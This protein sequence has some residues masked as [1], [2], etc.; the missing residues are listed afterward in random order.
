MS[1]QGSPSSAPDN[2]I[3]GADA[4]PGP[5]DS[6]A[7]LVRERLLRRMFVMG[8]PTVL[9][10]LAAA[11]AMAGVFFWMTRGLGALIWG[12]VI[13]AL[14]GLR[15]VFM[16]WNARLYP[17]PEF[18]LRQP[19]GAWRFMLPLGAYMSMWTLAPWALMPPGTES[20]MR[21][22]IL[23]LGMFAVLMGSVPVIAT[24]RA[25]VPVVTIP[26]TLGVVTR[27]AWMGG[28]DGWF[29]CVVGLL[30]G[31]SMARYALS[32]HQLIRRSL[33]DQIDKELLSEQLLRQS[34]EL[35]RLN[36]ERSRFFASASHDLRQPV[37]A[38]A[39]FS[40][41]LERDL[42]D[43][44]LAPV[45][46]RVVQATD[47]VSGL[48]NAM[49]DISKID[50]G[51]VVPQ[52]MEIA[53][54][55]L[56]L[57][58]SQLFE[59]RAQQ[60]GLS[61]RFHTGPEWLQTDADLLLRVLNNFVDNALK[62]TRRGGIL[63]SARPRGDRLR[64]AVWDTG[65]G[66][67]PEHLPHVFDEFYQVDN[68]QRDVARGLGIGLAIVKRLVDLLGGEVGVRSRQD[69][70]SVFWVDLPRR[71]PAPA[72]PALAPTATPAPA[73]IDTTELPLVPPRV[74]LLDDEQPV[75]EAVRMWLA[76]YC[77][78]IEITTRLS[79][80]CAQVRATPEDFD[81]FIVD[82]RLADPQDGIQAT[83][84]LRQ[85]AGRRVPTIL[86]TG[87]TDPE[88][89][90]AAYAS[91]LVVMFK[92]VQPEVLLRTLHQIIRSEEREPA[93]SLRRRQPP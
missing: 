14:L 47:A 76:P 87:D 29:T 45:A 31:G 55:P 50:A 59:P 27:F 39:L 64:L 66:I 24:W 30:F 75:G 88:R 46:G 33:S 36:R 6:H 73:A 53:V 82:F 8:P 65:L 2:T 18:T 57:R 3:T 58:L 41:S 4:P 51:T 69:H 13:C 21:I 40:R 10:A 63:V 54:D 61:L 74:L 37:H 49:L 89:V 71:R 68:P 67:A 11:I 42:A 19:D 43:H 38:L 12:F 52:P 91:D 70:G 26:L 34:F 77:E 56:F 5:G 80:A 81:A 25:M 22:L 79:D 44:P 20:P 23:L 78:R 86:V 35:Q 90:R 62:Y 48:L 93:L 17:E 16:R 9:T 60:A 32:Q 85:L 72:A 1:T 83:A 28:T 15:L 84:E 7:Q 92:P